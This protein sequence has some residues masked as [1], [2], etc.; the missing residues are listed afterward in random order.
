MRGKFFVDSNICLYILDK[1]SPKYSIVKQLLEDKPIISTQIVAENLNVCIKKFK[2][3]KADSISHANSLLQACEVRSV[4]KQTMNE[5]LILLDRFGYTIFDSLVLA[6]AY[7]AGSNTLFS[8]DMQ[9]GQL[10]YKK[11]KIVNPFKTDK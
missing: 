8:E 5:A 7:E 1:E 9:H 3:S 11:L 2:L 10:I 6:S 4:T